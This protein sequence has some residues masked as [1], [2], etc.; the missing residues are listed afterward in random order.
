MVLVVC[1]YSLFVYSLTF[2]L[3][4]PNGI[5]VLSVA[6]ADL[7]G[8]AIVPCPSCRRASGRTRCCSTSARWTSPARSTST[9]VSRGATRGAICPSPATL[10]P[11][12][13]RGSQLRL[14]QPE[15]QG[16][17]FRKIQEQS[18][19]LPCHPSCTKIHRPLRQNSW[20]P[21]YPANNPQRN[22]AL[23]TSR[24]PSPPGTLAHKIPS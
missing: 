14:T 21:A 24:R 17:H 4:D 16:D 11:P 6:A 18:R 2:Y 3:T 12:W 1:A 19:Q 5:M 8:G 13:P 15:D 22:T 20:R 9:A 7:L 10:P 23:E